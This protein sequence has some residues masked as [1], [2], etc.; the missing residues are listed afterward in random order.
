MNKNDIINVTITAMSAEGSG[1]AR[2]DGMAV[3]VPQTAIGDVAD[4]RIVKVKSRYAYGI[5]EKLIVPSEQ[6][7]SPDCQVFRKCGGC[8]YRHIDYKAE[9]DIK[10]TRVADAVKRIGGI[11]ME[12]NNII[13]AENILR[14]RNK[15]QYPVLSGGQVG[16]YATHSHRVIPCEDCLLQPEIFAFAARAFKDWITEN[17]VSVYDESTGKGL[18]RHFYLRYAEVSGEIMAVVVINGNTIPNSDDLVNKMKS[19]LGDALKSIQLNINTEDTNVILGKKCVL[20]YGQG[21]ITDTLCGVKVRLSPLSFYQVNRRMAER[22]YLKA[23]EYADAC[24]ED[25]LDLYCGAGTIGLSMAHSVKSV[26]GVEIVPQAVEDAK[27]NARENGIN[28]AEFICADAAAAAKQLAKRN[29]KP[30]VVIVDPPRKGCDESLLQTVANDFSPERI[31]YV[32]CDP[33][34]LARDAARLKE[35]GYSLMEYTPV[36]LFPRTSHVET[37]ALLVRTV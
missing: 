21:Y 19:A 2:V 22:L 26:I 17:N 12:P 33:S 20:L 24:G 1:I 4:I 9:C 36:D 10:Q 23:A 5:I 35:L 34:T 28:N 7:V 6:R 31:V 25:I 8:V 32:S 37:V 18:V 27:V 30:K 13:C 3:F 15:A 14:Y 16:F 29:I 11:D